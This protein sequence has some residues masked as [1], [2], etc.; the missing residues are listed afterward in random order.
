MVSSIEK[1]LSRNFYDFGVNELIQGR[2]GECCWTHMR[3]YFGCK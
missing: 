1:Q 3:S 2:T